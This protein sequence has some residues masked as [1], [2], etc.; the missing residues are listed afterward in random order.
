[1]ALGFELITKAMSVAKAILTGENV[2]PEVLEQR[3]AICRGCDLV[4]VKMNHRTKE[5][6]VSCGVCG[7][8]LKG[9]RSLVN[10]ARYVETDEYG[11]K[12]PSGSRWAAA[13]LSNAKAEEK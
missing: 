1:M 3:L 2:P 8:K 10:L 9:D 12:H 4:R 5:E 6:M 7:C 13:G 11:C